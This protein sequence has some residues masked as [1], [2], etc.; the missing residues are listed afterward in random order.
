MTSIKHRGFFCL[1]QQIKIAAIT[2]CNV[3]F[4]MPCFFPAHSPQTSCIW[5]KRNPLK[6]TKGARPKRGATAGVAKG[7]Q[8]EEYCQSSADFKQHHPFQRALTRLLNRL[9]GRKE[10]ARVRVMKNRV[11]TGKP[12]SKDS[13]HLKYMKANGILKVWILGTVKAG[14]KAIFLLLQISVSFETCF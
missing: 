10:K 7:A 1:L 3:C 2:L 14:G 12:G 9:N 13:Y 11:Q 5:S 4:I 8:E 6:S